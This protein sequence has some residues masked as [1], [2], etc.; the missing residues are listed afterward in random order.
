[1]YN[2][3]FWKNMENVWKHWDVKL[4]KTEKRKK[5]LVY[6]LKFFS[7]N[8]IAKK[9]KKISINKIVFLGLSILEISKIVMCQFWNDYIK[10]RYN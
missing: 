1:M 7:K 10:S 6:E 3:V 9:I 2:A 8:L 4:V 5:F